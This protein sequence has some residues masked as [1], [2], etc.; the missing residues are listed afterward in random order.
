[1]DNIEIFPTAQPY[2]ASLVRAS[3]VENPESYDG[4]TGLLLV[5]DNDGQAVR[6]AFTLRGQLYFV[7]EHS[8]YATQDDG[9]N[10]P[11]SGR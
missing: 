3:F 7:K 11:A 4:V 10:E 6:A 9:V 5:S 2:N 8:I 1:M